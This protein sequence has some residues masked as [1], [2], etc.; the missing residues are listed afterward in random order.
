MTNNDHIKYKNLSETWIVAQRVQLR[1]RN[2][3]PGLFQ[4]LKQGVP[5]EAIAGPPFCI[6]QFVSSVTDGYD[7]EICYP[8]EKAFGEASEMAR[9]LPG[10]EVLSLTHQGPIEELGASYRTLYSWTTERGIVSDEFGQEVYLNQEKLDQIEL[11]FVIHPWEKLLEGHLSRVLGEEGANQI[12]SGSEALTVSST[13]AERFDW[14]CSAVT[15]LDDTASEGEK[16]EVLSRCA[17]VFPARQISKLR[18]VYL[19]A[20]EQSGDMLDAVDAVIDFMA[21]DPGWV[22]RPRRDGYTIFDS[23]SPRDPAGC[24]K[25]E[26]REEKRKAYCYCPLIRENLGGGMPAAFCYCGAGWYRQQWEGAIGGPVEVEIVRSLLKGD[27]RCEFAI[28]LPK[29]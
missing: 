28:K 24:E 2:Q 18:E 13:V 20:K 17:H 15:K 14:V 8:V 21:E 23:K 4:D 19:E 12:I 11:Q 1:D 7:A 26:S 6:I 5:D 27:D 3:L 22:D 9:L 16:Y 10:R 25:A 29:E